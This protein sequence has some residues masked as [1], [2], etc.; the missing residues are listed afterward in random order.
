M[1]Y[2][3]KN[4]R[5]LVVESSPVMFTLIKDVLGVFGV[6]GSNIFSAYSV[7]EGYDSFCRFNQDLLI[8]DWLTHVDNGV[9]LTKLVRTDVSTPNRFVPII[10]TAGS[11]HQSKVLQALNAGI[12]EYLVKPFSAGSLAN[13]ITRVIEDPKEFIISEE[14][15]GPKRGENIEEIEEARKAGETEKVEE[16]MKKAQELED[17][18]KQEQN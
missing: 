10:M 16:A 4:V 17:A 12:S 7:E 8:I 15:T 3:F 11:G 6:S 14:Y 1:S 5:V 13:R 2:D 18:E 9:D